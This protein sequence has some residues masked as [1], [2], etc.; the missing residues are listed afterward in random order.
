MA[1]NIIINP[2]TDTSFFDSVRRLL[3]GIDEETL[4]ND[5]IL[6]PAF[7]D[8]AEMDILSL[9]PCLDGTDV[10]PLDRSRA[11][12]A[13]IYLIASKLCSTIK[14]LVEYELKTIDV[15]WKK[16]PIEYDDLRDD[17]LSTVTTLLS[18]ISCY[19]DQGKSDIFVVAPSKRA[20]M[21]REE[22]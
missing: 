10:D 19:Q 7:F 15:S 5:M 12:L 11:R 21:E 4:T 16:K 13:M 20:V 1:L 2:E 8:M 18:S 3:G 6:D 9:V 17:L 22:L 14:G